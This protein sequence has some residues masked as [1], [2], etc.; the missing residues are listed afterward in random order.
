MVLAPGLAGFGEDETIDAL[1]RRFGYAGTP[2]ILELART[3]EDLRRN[4][5]AAAHLIHGSSEGR[6]TITYCPGHLTRRE[7]EDAGFC[8]APSTVW[9]RGTKI[10]PTVSMNCRTEKRFSISNPALGLWAC[11]KRF[12]PA[13]PLEGRK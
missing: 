4:L 12:E 10:L 3:D 2:R 1:I 11:R 8:Y 5:G 9:Q 13:T 7:I 6:F